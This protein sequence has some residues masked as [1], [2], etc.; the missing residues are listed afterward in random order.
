M[1]LMAPTKDKIARVPT[2]WV[3]GASLQI[4]AELEELLLAFLLVGEQVD[5]VRMEALVQLLVERQEA[6]VPVQCVN[7]MIQTRELVI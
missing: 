7:N 5:R 6:V 2:E 4:M 3:E 1:K